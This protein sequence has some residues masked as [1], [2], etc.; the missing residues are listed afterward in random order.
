[1]ELRA[2]LSI[3]LT[4]R[5]AQQGIEAFQ[6]LQL[7]SEI[8]GAELVWLDDE[9]RAARAV[10]N[11]RRLLEED[12]VHI[13]FGPYSSGLAL[14]VMKVAEEHHKILWNYGGSSDDVAGR[15]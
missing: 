2:G 15:W 13:L 7:W 4:G 8:A 9:S 11:S 5:Y 3:S 12:R 14:A 1:M 10:G 6:A